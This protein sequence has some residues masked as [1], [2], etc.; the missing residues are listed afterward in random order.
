MAKKTNAD[1]TT[2]EW[3]KIPTTEPTPSSDVYEQIAEAQKK[4]L[5][6]SKHDTKKVVPNYTKK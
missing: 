6:R 2:D 5:V 4:G 3:L 1:A